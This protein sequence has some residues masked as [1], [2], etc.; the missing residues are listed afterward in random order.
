[1]TEEQFLGVS[2]HPAYTG[3]M[4]PTHAGLA[5]AYLT[6]V[7]ADEFHGEVV[8]GYTVLE[9]AGVIAAPQ[10]ITPSPAEI[11]PGPAAGKRELVDLARSLQ[12][13]LTA[14]EAEF[15]HLPVF[16]RPMAR[17]GLKSRSG[18]SLADWQRSAARFEGLMMTPNSEHNQADLQM[19]TSRLKDLLPKLVDYFAGVP[20]ETARFTKDQ[21]MLKE[22]SRIAEMRVATL[23]EL[24]EGLG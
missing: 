15:N 13:M 21:E 3:M 20:G 22:V 8:T 17:G 11:K 4:P 19:E 18:Q 9:R 24:I 2:F 10:A 7:L 12:E 6:A 5:T 16:V 23:K 14:T 1:M